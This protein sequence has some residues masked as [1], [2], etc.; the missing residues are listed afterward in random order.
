MLVREYSVYTCMLHVYIGH[1]A[2][3]R[4]TCSL[5]SGNT[6]IASC[7]YLLLPFID[8]LVI[9]LVES[10]IAEEL[11]KILKFADIDEVTRYSSS[12]Y[13]RHLYLSQPIKE[14]Q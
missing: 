3:Y 13:I 12:I 11:V 6:H 14:P 10:G 1:A 7:T 9:I 5:N 4:L 2:T 8:S